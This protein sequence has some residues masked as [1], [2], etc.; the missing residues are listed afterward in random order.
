MPSKLLL[1]GLF[2]LYP[3]KNVI[4]NFIIQALTKDV[5]HHG[6]EGDEEDDDEGDDDEGDDDDDD[7]DD[8]DRDDHQ[9]I[10]VPPANLASKAQ[11]GLQSTRR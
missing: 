3:A 7:D 1:A 9:A 8:G 10:L 6:E 4:E 2:S 5:H 11:P